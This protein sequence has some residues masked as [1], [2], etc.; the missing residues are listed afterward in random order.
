MRRISTWLFI[1]TFSLTGASFGEEG[2]GHL[3]EVKPGPSLHQKALW[4]FEAIDMDTGKEIFRIGNSINDSLAPGSLIKLLTA[5]AVLDHEGRDG[6]IDMTTTIL[7][8][9]DITSNTLKGN[10]YITGRG[11]AFLSGKDLEDA[12][13]RIHQMGLKEITGDI[14]ADATLFDTMGLERKRKG[15]AYAPACALG[16]DLHTAAVLVMPAEPGKAPLVRMEPT[17]DSV[18][19][20]VSART[21]S[22]GLNTIEIAQIDDTSYKVTGN[23]PAGSGGVKKRFAL[24]DPALYAAGTLKTL[25]VNTGIEVKGSVKK[26]SAPKGAK[27]MAEIEAPALD[28]LIK[29]MNVNSLNVV[30]DNLLLLLGERQDGTPGTAD[31]GLAAVERFLGALGLDIDDVRIEDGSGLSDGNRVTSKFMARYL[32]KVSKRPWFKG[33]EKSLPN[34]G[35]GTLKDIGFADTRFRVKTG[36]LEDTFAIAG[37]GVDARGKSIAFSYIVNVPGA[38][39]MGLNT[40]GAEVM[41]YLSTEVVQ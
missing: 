30:A 24:K 16:L 27:V 4:T 31:K 34:A 26:G 33:F 28:G 12:V 23:I 41:K 1:W 5:G 20:S 17:N 38:G 40:T 36:S 7:H 18:R 22:G 9:G 14:V 8:G 29:D 10:L 2:K 21:V 39:V 35:E 3:L 32:H 6:G 15:P 25:L 13:K 11:N 37:Y 19:F